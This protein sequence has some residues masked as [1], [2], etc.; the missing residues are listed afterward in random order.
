MMW[1]LLIALSFISP[2]TSYNRW[3]DDVS[4]FHVACMH[5]LGSIDRG[6]DWS[7]CNLNVEYNSAQ[8]EHSKT[9]PHILGIYP[10]EKGK[11]TLS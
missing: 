6:L 2:L 9:N 11:S 7:S 1:I 10:K 5:C 8:Y 4:G 3:T